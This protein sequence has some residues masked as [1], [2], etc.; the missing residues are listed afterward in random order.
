[1]KFFL[2]FKSDSYG[3]KQ[4]ADPWGMENIIFSLKQKPNGMGR[5]R[6]F[7]AD[8][9]NMFEFTR[10]ADH[11]LDQILYYNRRFGFESDADLEFNIDNST[12]KT[13]LDFA[14]AE[15]DDYESFK[16]QGIEDSKLQIINSR[17]TTKVNLFADTDV[18]GN[19]I[20]P[21]VPENMFINAT[22]VRKKS[23]WEQVES[24]DRKFEASGS[25]LNS[26]VYVD[27]FPCQNL[28]E[29]GINDSYTFFELY[30]QRPNENF[31]ESQYKLMT[32]QENCKN[33]QIK[34][35]DILLH[36]NTDVDN[37]G[38]GYVDFKL[39][40]RHG[41]EFNTATVIELI[42]VTKTEFQSYDYAG[43]FN[44]TINELARG[45]SVWVFF[46]MK[47]RQ[48]A[49]VPL[50]TERFEVFF[51]LSN[52]VTEITLDSIG[53]SSIAPSLRLIDVIRQ[54]I[55]SIS[56]LEINADRFDTGTILYDQRLT[57]GNL[58]RGKTDK[59]FSISLEDLEKS[60]TE[61][62]SDYEIGSDGKVFF[63]IEEDFYTL[64][65][66]MFFSQKQFKEM[67][68]TYNPK[69]TV[70]EF[71]F[72]YKKFQS[73][74][75]N[76]LENNSNEVHGETKYSF[77]NKKVE[78]KKVVEVEWI[79][80]VPLIEETRL[81]VFDLSENTSSQDDD[82]LFIIDSIET[83]VDKS[84]NDVYN[85]SHSYNSSTMKLV[86][87]TD[88]SINFVALG[89]VVGSTF[90]IKTPDINAGNYEVFAVTQSE[91]QLTRTSAGMVSGA[92]DGIR[93]TKFTY[94]IAQS[95]I[96]FTNRTNEGFS[97]IENIN[98]SDTYSNL[99]F[100]KRRNIKNYWEKYIA[101][102]NLFWKDK[103]LKNFWYKNNPTCRTVYLGDDVIENSDIN[104]IN[105]I[106]TPRLYNN[107]VFSDVKFSE[108]IELSDKI[109]SIR[110]YIRAIDHN[111]RVIKFYPVDVMYSLKDETLT[112]KAEEKYEP[113]TMKITSD[114]SFI[115]VNDET[116]VNKVE[117]RFEGQKLVLLDDSKQRL[118]NPVYWMEV[119][120]NGAIPNSIVQLEEWLNLL[121]I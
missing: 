45:E 41:L 97:T 82:S 98:G 56:G 74:K 2:N 57:N 117:F 36:F 110:G 39:E 25:G 42:N 60:L 61:F 16:C 55:K 8:T 13:N 75:E 46:Y 114:T 102:C 70:N 119:S 72:M 47:I 68:N 44:V 43:D 34:L 9:N 118:Y 80:S 23:R 88:G 78:N 111:L 5:D 73:Q 59:P 7:A 109:R 63:G 76:E 3:K 99:R 86:L 83:T 79:R 31:P 20:S 77:F 4:I 84:I 106:L 58:L 49:S 103:P 10:E 21:L 95:V 19:Y 17:K 64:N 100:T 65:E 53:F 115:T 24:I 35:S 30:R 67:N 94:Y 15:T 14:T 71:H 113:N 18:D 51:Q 40:V 62:R 85:F 91:L 37:G 81:K 69:F 22:P 96:P 105:P 107:I 52:M 33:V 26:N 1:M 104:P 12:Y 108:F 27:L 120:V 89:I 6:S 38:D 101:T 54:V 28:A 87:R 32:A 116:R 90:V 50:V 121:N 112:I 92:G 93:Q 29:A 48:S 66:M 11:Y